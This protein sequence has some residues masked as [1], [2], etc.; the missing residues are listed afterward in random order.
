MLEGNGVGSIIEQTKDVQI[1]QTILDNSRQVEE[2]KKQ[3]FND[4]LMEFTYLIKD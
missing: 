3:L 4:N 1:K 2:N